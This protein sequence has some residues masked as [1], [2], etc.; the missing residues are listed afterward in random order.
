MAESSVPPGD[1]PAARDARD[2]TQLLAEWRR[3]DAG[4]FEMLFGRLYHDLRQRAH[5]CLRGE[6]DDHTL[7]TT[8]LVHESYFRLVDLERIDWQDR[9][10]FLAVA[11]RAMRR[12]LVSYA[13]QHRAQKRGGGARLSLEDAPVLAEMRADELVALDLA[14]QKLEA[15][16]PRLSQTV[17]LRFFGGLTIEETAQ[18]V[19]LAPSTVK[20]DW[21]KA[22]AWL[23]RELAG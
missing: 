7:C 13:R 19:G 1:E 3:G 6:R 10:H 4:A 17:E 18:A 15:L 23:Y 20:L 5:A 21:E 2:V 12:V 16:A 14:L 11:S 22:R 9:G 8:D